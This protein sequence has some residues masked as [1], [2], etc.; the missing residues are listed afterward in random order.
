[1]KAMIL[2]LCILLLFACIALTA[3][4]LLNRYFNYFEQQDISEPTVWQVKRL[5]NKFEPTAPKETRFTTKPVK[6]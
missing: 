3:L 2:L 6:K 5:D 1:M 4:W